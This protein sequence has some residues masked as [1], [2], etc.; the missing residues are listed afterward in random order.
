MESRVEC[1]SPL[2]LKQRL[3]CH[4]FEG[5]Y[6]LHSN[7]KPLNLWFKKLRTQFSFCHALEGALFQGSPTSS[8]SSNLFLHSYLTCTGWI[9]H[10][11]LQHLQTISLYSVIMIS[12]FLLLTRISSPTEF[13]TRSSFAWACSSESFWPTLCPSCHSG[14]VK[15]HSSPITCFVWWFQARTCFMLLLMSLSIHWDFPIPK[16]PM[17][18]C[19]QFTGNLTLHYSF[20]ILLAYSISM[21]FQTFSSIACNFKD[22]RY[23][24]VTYQ[25]TGYTSMSSHYNFFHKLLLLGSSPNTNSDQRESTEIKDPAESKDPALPNSCSSNLTFDAATTFCRKIKFFKDKQ[26][27]FRK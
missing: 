26:V 10:W 27:S 3:N 14:K 25:C 12:L 8:H 5:T 11:I 4:W 7:K 23:L 18:W 9:S 24:S 22:Y 19:I 17:L 15:R 13:P 6:G 21:V 20:F 1:L 16:T 2:F